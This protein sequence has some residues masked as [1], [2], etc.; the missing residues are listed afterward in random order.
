[1]PREFKRSDRVADAIQRS[2]ARILQM[3]LRDPRLGMANINSVTVTKDLAIAKVY[4]TFVGQQDGEESEAGVQVLN[5]AAS[6]VRNLMAKDLSIR[7]IPK[8]QFYF[9]KSTIAG[10]EISHLIDRAVA[11]D[12]AHAEPESD[13]EKASDNQSFDASDAPPKED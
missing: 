8:L 1:M 10:Q 5:N 4:V 7:T 12:R 11:A 2:L 13:N 3:E 9:D 6:Y